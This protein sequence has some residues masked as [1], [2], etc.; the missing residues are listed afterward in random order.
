MVRVAVLGAGF[1]G[2]VHSKAYATLPDAD[3]AVIYSPSPDRGQPLAEELGVPW[4]DNLDAILAD[5][6]VD[7]VDICLPT[8]QHR[9]VTE[10]A[11]AAGKHVLLE[12]PIAMTLADAQ[13]LVTLADDSDRTVM[14]AHVLRF[15]PE[16]VEIARQAHAGDLGRLRSGFASRRQP[17]PAWSKLFSRSDLT[18]GAVIDMMIHDFDALNWVFGTPVAVTARGEQNERS[19]G[20]FDQVQVL[21]DYPNGTS[22]LVDGGMT[23]PESYPFSSRLEVL[24]EDAA[25]EYTFRAGGRSVEMG[26]GV[27]E[28]VLYPNAGDPA[29]LELAQADPYANEC[30][31]FLD[32]IRTGSSPDRATPHDGL[33]ALA[34]AL[35][36]RQSLEQGGERV[37]VQL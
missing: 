18:G 19:G 3:I 27:N 25:V 22:A 36:A 21:I 5:P 16:Y 14:M 15:W 12:K 28:L 30:A 6:G 13:A 2:G 29:I 32:A 10:A 35:A 24:G 17:F 34:T 1:M 31:A 7:A 11:I 20:G 37:E 26:S 23:M 33:V 8:P 4:S 9:P